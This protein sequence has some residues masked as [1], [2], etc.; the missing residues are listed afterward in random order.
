MATKECSLRD[1]DG[2]HPAQLSQ[3]AVATEGALSSALQRAAAEAA[4][5]GFV[6]P[7]NLR[8][9]SFRYQARMVSGLAPTEAR[10][11]ELQKSGVNAKLIA[12]NGITHFETYRFSDALRQAIPWLRGVWK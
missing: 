3:I 2:M 5:R 11:T 10:I 12:L 1:K 9:I 8:A 4:A 7:S 6:K